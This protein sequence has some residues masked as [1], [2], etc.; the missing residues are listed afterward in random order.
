MSQT[1]YVVRAPSGL[2]VAVTVAVL[3]VI[4]DALTAEI[5]GPAA[6]SADATT[7]ALLGNVM[8]NVAVMRASLALVLLPP[9]RKPIATGTSCGLLVA[10]H[11]GAPRGSAG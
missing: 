10:R 6:A 8:A 2:M 4:S 5:V 1:S 11:S 3:G 7:G 9:R